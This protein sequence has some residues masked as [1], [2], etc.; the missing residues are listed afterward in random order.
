MSLPKLTI[1]MDESES[2][3]TLPHGRNGKTKHKSKV[4]AR[5]SVLYRP[6]EE[7]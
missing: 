3:S 6:K 1:T 5:A 4:L 2:T 7:K